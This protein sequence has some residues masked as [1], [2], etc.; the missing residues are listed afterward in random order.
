MLDLLNFVLCIS[1]LFWLK[2]SIM[3]KTIILFVLSLS[4]LGG[5]YAWLKV[6]PE[7]PDIYEILQFSI[8]ILLV[9]FAV[10]L[11]IRRIKS[12][13]EGLPPEDE[14]SK[15]ILKIAAARA[16]YFSLYLWL[17]LMYFANE[18]KVATESLMS[19]GILGMALLL[20]IHY[21]IIKF[22]GLKNE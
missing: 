12:Q 18:G 9:V 3:K 8:V 11:G 5:I 19:T 16:Y 22:T 20:L 14:M 17:I 4:V 13:R 10:V 1:N 6:N 21:L 7:P 15:K 2:I